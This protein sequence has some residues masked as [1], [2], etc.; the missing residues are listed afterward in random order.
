MCWNPIVSFAFG[1]IHLLTHY[2]VEES[3][4]EENEKQSYLRFLR[5]YLL[6]EIFQSLQW[7]AGEVYPIS[8]EFG[9]STCSSINTLFTIIAYGL[10]WWQ[11]VLFAYLGNSTYCRRFAILTFI[12]AMVTLIAGLKQ[13]PSYRLPNSNYGLTTCTETGIYGHLAWKFSP[14][15]VIMYPNFYSYITSILLSIFEMEVPLRWTIGMGWIITLIVSLSYV[16]TSVDLPAFWCL[17]SVFV[18][19]P[20][21]I[22]VSSFTL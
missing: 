12:V 9:L 22:R 16:G 19:I 8:S 15:S 10:I 13:I 7:V 4:L 5:F 6:M 11:P 17:L 18:D 14:V 20:I 1:Y 3:S 2:L 21:I